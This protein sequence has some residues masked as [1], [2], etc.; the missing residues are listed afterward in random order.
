[1]DDVKATDEWQIDPRVQAQRDKIAK[2]LIEAEGDDGLGVK[3]ITKLGKDKQTPLSAAELRERD[4][5]TQADFNAK[6]NTLNTAYT[7]T[8]REHYASKTGGGGGEGERVVGLASESGGE[9]AADQDGEK[10][11]GLSSSLD[12]E[13]VEA[14]KSAQ[15]D[16]NGDKVVGLASDLFPEDRPKLPEPVFDDATF[17]DYTKQFSS[18]AIKSIGAIFQGGGELL[19]KGLNKTLDTEEFTAVNP[20]DYFSEALESSMTEGGKKALS[21][22]AFHGDVLAPE[23]WILPKSNQGKAMFVVQGFGSLATW[24]IPMGFA[25]KGTAK[26]AA[27]AGMITGGLTTGGDA[28]GDA[29]ENAEAF[30]EGKSHESLMDLVPTYK[31]AFEKY[32]DEA[33]AKQSVINNAGFLAASISGSVG[34]VEGA[35]IGKALKVM[36]FPTLPKVGAISNPIL[37]RGTAFAGGAVIEG[38]QEVLEKMG[39]NAGENIALGREATDDITRNTAGEAAGGALVGAHV[40]AAGARKDKIKEEADAYKRKKQMQDAA[41][42]LATEPTDEELDQVNDAMDSQVDAEMGRNETLSGG[43]EILNDNPTPEPQET[44]QAQVD[45]FIK[46]NKPAILLTD[47][48]AVPDNLPDDVKME[49]VEDG[50][51]IYRDDEVLKL[52]QNG[53][54][55][56]A[57]GYGIDKKPAGTNETVT[58]RDEKGTVIQDVLT[59]GSQEVLDAA[60]EVAGEDGTVEVR[61]AEE[62]I[63]ERNIAQAEEQG[64][65]DYEANQNE[66]IS[67]NTGNASLPNVS[68][69]AGQTSDNAE[70]GAT[71]VADVS[72]TADG[73]NTDIQQT[74]GIA[75]EQSNKSDQSIQQDDTE[76]DDALSKLKIGETITTGGVKYRKTEDGFVLVK[77]GEKLTLDD[78]AHDAATSERN[79]E[80]E[81]TQAQ[82]EAG[83]YKVGS[84]KVGDM[85][86]SIENPDQ[87]K[88][89]GVDRDGKAWESIMNG[90]YGYV[91][92]VVARAPDKE[93][94]DV[95]IKVGTPEDHSGDVFV[96]NQ[97]DPRTGKFDEPKV[98]IGYGSEAEARKAYE[99]NYAKGWKGLGSIAKISMENFKQRLN[100]KDGFIAP[101]VAP[102]QVDESTFKVG[103]KVKYFEGKDD[104]GELDTGTYEIKGVRDQNGE[105]VADFTN[106]KWAHLEY[107]EVVKDDG[108]TDVSD[109]AREHVTEMVKRRAAANEMGKGRLFNSILQ[110]AK[111]FMN[112]ETIRPKKLLDASLAFKGDP[113]LSKALKAL[114]DLATNKP[115]KKAE[116]EKKAPEVKAEPEKVEAKPDTTKV[117]E[118]AT[119]KA[120]IAHKRDF[121][122][123]LF[124]MAVSLEIGESQDYLAFA[125]ANSATVLEA[126]EEMRK[127]ATPEQALALDQYVK[128]GKL[129]MPAT[130]WKSAFKDAQKA[131]GVDVSQKNKLK[132][133]GIEL[134]RW[135]ELNKSK[136]KKAADWNAID[137]V[138]ARSTV[139]KPQIAE[140]A[141]ENLQP[142]LDIFR[143]TVR[144]FADYVDRVKYFN[145]YGKMSKGTVQAIKNYLNGD[146]Y[147]SKFSEDQPKSERIELIRGY[148]QE[149]LD[150]INKLNEMLNGVKTIAEVVDRVRKTAKEGVYTKLPDWIEYSESDNAYG[151][152]KFKAIEDKAPDYFKKFI[153]NYGNHYDKAEAVDKVLARLNKT[154]NDEK[155]SI[156]PDYEDWFSA[157]SYLNRIAVS[158]ADKPNLGRKLALTRPRLDKIER[159]GR[160]DY[161]KGKDVT[162]QQLKDTFGLADVIFGKYVNTVQDQKH[163]NYAF[164]ALHD[165]S[166]VLGLP[167]IAMGLGGKLHL[168]IGALGH[169]KA[170]AHYADNQPDG[171]GGTVH[172]MNFTNTRGDGTVAHEWTH[173]LDFHLKH[174][175]Q[176]GSSLLRQMRS[177]LSK[178]HTIDRAKDEAKRFILYSTY[179]PHMKNESKIN[180]AIYHLKHRGAKPEITTYKQEA[181]KLG[182]DYWGNELELL[183]RASEAYIYDQMNNAETQSDY[184]VSDWVADGKVTSKSYRGTPYPEATERKT[185]NELFKAFYSSLEADAK[186]VR[187]NKDKFNSS[188]TD[189]QIE[190]NELLEELIENMPRY[191][192]EWQ[193]EQDKARAA[194]MGESEESKAFV[195]EQARIANEAENARIEQAVEDAL[196]PNVA[197]GPLSESDLEAIF[198]EAANELTEAATEQPETVVGEPTE[199]IDT[200]T[201]ARNNTAPTSS[202]SPDTAGKI[203]AK[204]ANL[205]VKGIDE[206][207]TGLVKLFGGSDG[208]RL[209]SFPSGMDEEAYNKAK[210]HFEAALKAFIEAGKTVKDLFRFLIENFGVGIK[211]YAIRFA[212]E[213]NLS[214]QLSNDKE[215]EANESTTGEDSDNRGDATAR[216]DALQGRD[217]IEDANENSGV[218]SER[219]DGA[220]NGN[221][222]SGTQREAESSAEGTQSSTEQGAGTSDSELGDVQ[223]DRGND[224]R[225]GNYVIPVGGLTRE[226]S[227]RQSAALNLDIIELIGKLEDE[228]RQATPAEQALLSKYVGFGSAEIRNTLFNPRVFHDGKYR[229]AW[230]QSAWGAE[231]LRVEQL[232]TPEQLKSVLRSTQYAHY[233]P[234]SMTRSIWAGL[235]R[236]GYSGGKVFEAG[237]GVGNFFGTMPEGMAKASNYTGVEYDQLTASIAKQLYPNENV[238]Q[239]D[240]TETKLPDN[241]FD[242][243]IGNPPFSQTRITNDP[244]YRKKSFVMHDYFI[245]KSLDKVREG[246]LAVF[247]TSKGTMDALNDRARKDISSQ[248]DLIGAIRMPQTAFKENA[249]TETITDVI[250]LRKR[251]KSEEAGGENWTGH[252]ELKLHDSNGNQ[253]KMLVNEYFVKHPEMVL[254]NHAV[255]WGQRGHEYTVTPFEDQTIE[256]GFAKAVENLPENVYST[257]KASKDTAIKAV[258]ERDLN[259]LNKK[260]GGM[261]VDDKGK[262]MVVDSG[263]GVAASSIFNLNSNTE[264]WLKDYVKVRDAVKQS[265]YDQW[266]DAN[267]EASLKAL[268]KVYD[269]FVKKH[270]S[271]KAFTSSFRNETDD[272]GVVTKMERRRFKNWSTINKDV[273]GAFV[274]ALED[275]DDTGNI[276]KAA[277]LTKRTAKKPV[278]VKIETIHDALAVSLD[279]VGNLD[280]DIIAE[281]MSLTK[282]QVISELGDMIYE[283][284]SDNE[285]QMHDEYLSGKVIDKLEEAE[286]AAKI[287]HRFERNVKALLKVQPRPIPSS[288]ITVNLGVNWIKPDVIEA[289]AEEVLEEGVSVKYGIA[290]GTW[291]ADG[292]GSRGYQR[293]STTSWGTSD[294]SAAEILTAVLNGK[295]LEI[296]RTDQETKKT[297]TDAVATA[298]VNDIANKMRDSF[299]TWVWIDS[300]RAAALT[301]TYN[302]EFNNVVG[303]TFDGSHMS[304]AGMTTTIDLHPHQKR[305]IWRVVQTGSTYLDHAVGAGKTYEM[306]ASGMEQRRLGLIRRPMYVVP[307]HMLEQFATE[308]IDLYPTANIMVA[309]KEN[310]HADTR[311]RFLAQASMNDPDAI[312]ITHSAF[313]LLGLSAENAN[314]IIEEQ[315]DEL[316]M[317]LDEVEADGERVSI[318]KIQQ[319]IESLEKKLKTKG[320]TDAKDDAITFEDMGVDMLYVDEAHEFRK[321]DFA[322]NKTKVKGIDPNGSAKAMDLYTK[323]RYLQSLN[324]TRSHVFASGTPVTNTMGELYTIMKFFARDE[325]EQ[326]GLMHFDS[327]AAMF[328]DVVADYEPNA[329]G[330]YELVERFAKFQNVPELMKRIRTF[331]DVLTSNDLG[332]L[333]TRPTIKGGSRTIVITPMPQALREY[334]DNVL[335]PRIAKSKAWKP[336]KSEPNN[337]DPIIAIIGDARLA[338]ID[339]R[340]VNPE[341]E[342]DPDSKLN[343]MID[344]IIETFNRSKNTVYHDAWTKIA[345]KIKG[346]TQIVFANVGFGDQVAKNRGFSAKDW[347]NKRLKDAGMKQSEIAWMGEYN[348]SLKKEAMFMQMRSGEKKILFGSPKNMG[349]GVNVQS[350]LFALHYLDA[351]WY[352]SDLEQ[353]EGRIYRQKNKNPEIELNAYATKGSYDS[354]MWQTVARKGRFIE[355]AFNGDDSVRT[356]E[357]VSESSNYQMAAALASG[358]DRVVKLAGLESAIGKLERLKS[359][360]SRTQNELRTKMVANGATIRSLTERI[361]DSK[362][363]VKKTNDEYLGSSTKIK[364]GKKE[365]VVAKE[366]GE[367]IIELYQKLAKT[368]TK[369]ADTAEI[370]V[371]AGK[372]SLTREV[373]SSLGTTEPTLTINVTDK[374]KFVID[375]GS[376]EGKDPSGLVSRILNQINRV[377]T[378]LQEQEM[379]LEGAEREKKNIESKLGAPY[380]N[381]QELNEKIAEAAQ[382]KEELASTGDKAEIVEA[383]SEAATDENVEYWS[384]AIWEN[385][386]ESIVKATRVD[387]KRLVEADARYKDIVLFKHYSPQSDD[388]SVTEQT[389]GRRITHDSFDK[390]EAQAIDAL[391]THG[392]D[393]FKSLVDKSATVS[394]VPKRWTEDDTAFLTENGTIQSKGLPLAEVEKLAAQVAKGWKRAPEI[395]VIENL[396][397]PRVNQSVRDK[398][399]K[400]EANG[401]KKIDLP[402]A[403]ISSGKVY[404]VRSK[405]NNIRQVA[406]AVHHEIFGHYGLRNNFGTALNNILD[407]IYIGR[408]DEVKA[409]AKAYG[410]DLNIPAERRL[411]AEEV[412][413]EMAQKNPQLGLVQRAI[414]AIRTWLR[415]TFDYYKD[416]EITDAEIINSILIPARDFVKNSARSGDGNLLG[417]K[418]L[419]PVYSTGNNVAFNKESDETLFNLPKGIEFKRIPVNTSAMPRGAVEAFIDG[420]KVGS[421][422]LYVR[423]DKFEV[424]TIDV[425]KEYRRQGIASELI[426]EAQRYV[427]VDKLFTTLQTPEGKKL[428]STMN[429]SPKGDIPNLLDQTKTASFKK[430]FGDSKVVD[431]NGNPKVMYHGTFSNPQIFEEGVSEFGNVAGFF[432]PSPYFA[433]DY[434]VKYWEAKDAIDVNEKS[435]E[436]VSIQKVYIKAE[437]PFDYNNKAHVKQLY[438]KIKDIESDEEISIDSLSTGDYR[439]YESSREI[440]DEI[441]NLGFDSVWVKESGVKNITVFN[442]NQIKS[443]IGNNGNFDANNDDIAFS[444]ANSQQSWEDLQPNSLSKTLI[445]ALQDKNVD[446]KEV[447]KNIKKSVG[448]IADKVNAYLQEELYHGRTAKRTKDFIKTELEPLIDSMRLRGVEM[449]DFEEYLWARHA[450]ERNI[451]IAKINPEMP[452]GGSGMMTADAIGYLKRL[453]PSQ[454]R[455]FEA[456]AKRID[457]ISKKS[458]Q[459]LV[460]YGI[461][462]KSTIAAWEGAY[463]HYVPLM[464]EDMDHGFGNG[465]G[466]GF[467]VKGNA[468]KRATGSKRAVVDIIANLAQ[469]RE[470]N[471]IRGEKNRVSTALIG[472]AKA[473]PNPKFW[474]TEKPPTITTVSKPSS[475][476][477]VLY[478][479]SRVRSFTTENAAKDYIAYEGKNG[480]TIDEIKIPARVVTTIDP[481]YKNRNEVIVARIPDENGKIKEMSVIFNEHDKRAMRM[482]ASLKNLDQDQ[483]KEVL[484]ASAS[485][486]RYFASINT[487][488]NPI[489][490]LINITR[491]V[492]GSILNLSSTPLK[493]KQ[494]EVLK[495]TGS[496]LLGIYRDLRKVRK[497]GKGVDSK[498][499]KLFEE[500]Q[501]EGGQTGYRDMFRNAEARGNAIKKT[502]DPTW[503]QNTKVGKAVTLNGLIAKPEQ[504]LLEKGQA[505]IFDFLSDY[506][507]ALENAVRLSTYKVAKDNGQTNQQAASLAKNISVNFN[508]KGEM[509]REVGSLYAF[510]NASVQG[511]ARIM[512][513]MVKSEDGKISFTKAGAKIFYGG[514]LLGAIQAVMLA[515]FGY[516]EDEPPKF[517]RDRSLII[518]LD[519][520]GADKKYITIPMPLGF[521]AIPSTGRILTEWMLSGFDD[522]NERFMGFMDMLLDVTNPIGNAGMSMQT[523]T[524]TALDPIAALTENKDWTGKP[525]A[526]EDFNSLNPTAGHTRGRDT[527]SMLGNGISH[528]INWMTGGNE[529]KAGVISPTPDH[530]DYLIGQLAGGVGREAMKIQQAITAVKTG[531]E[532]PPYKRPVIGRFYGEA[533]SKS[534][535]GGKFYK[536]IIRLNKLE[537]ELKGRREAKDDV[538]GFRKDNPEVALISYANAAQSSISRLRKQKRRLIENNASKDRIEAVNELI[539][540]KMRR[541]NEKVYSEAN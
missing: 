126:I 345:E 260:E 48:E 405:V 169:G 453:T 221:D 58:A 156:L 84:V 229:P 121:D 235:E 364:V 342:S 263:S 90:H 423:G 105:K 373:V 349:T 308:F 176:Q 64:I 96:I 30:F 471:L 468:S 512:E 450:E 46:G 374:V 346:S 154:L 243:T 320:E 368:H 159:K 205:G 162:P 390:V 145:T 474:R 265:R 255:R 13:W 429:A 113:A 490:G 413:A 300:N 11:V 358:D 219:N 448:G 536:N 529:Y 417:I 387:T 51:L 170:A 137:K 8:D 259:P 227:W 379:A 148:A 23:T 130:F 482:S 198:D 140:G 217:P 236:L 525:I 16:E 507:D 477:D 238:I 99:S 86:V 326:T 391:I 503:W 528:A 117:D 47:G 465:T 253:V 294:R 372:Y 449:A 1:M 315:L 56:E 275:V 357:D 54:I 432:T 393:K 291:K 396:D 146:S 410:L 257:A 208:G 452:D 443:A 282:D 333:V 312:I 72:D 89:K 415:K 174:Y 386:K 488:Y 455:N 367:A 322:T 132:N 270:G 195:A 303:R 537:T 399:V 289:F 269:G 66:T 68:R 487:Q 472:L 347:V 114:Y 344:G 32:G 266:N 168:A 151:K 87:S 17:A 411:A 355:Q 513:T 338:N 85:V 348:T 500:F 340:F 77:D 138:T 431:E 497:S 516:D 408:R 369:P 279:K 212:K 419:K 111:D 228:K 484:S 438:N 177:L 190:Y 131:A 63:E 302:R 189:P 179:Y 216:P 94:V 330:R 93:H 489:F 33:R 461:E 166:D 191:A 459:V 70:T 258:A 377:S 21:E 416:S 97:N 53:Q 36:K 34:A 183:A 161:R 187:V 480:F 496:A 382:L 350:R 444:L 104:Y 436:A 102:R 224:G 252:E 65:A 531:E 424:A 171:K 261:Y 401:A 296:K 483:M 430:W 421:V 107:L 539:T 101:V 518:P 316:R 318:K 75:D 233:T 383:A 321:L 299:K 5:P 153:D 388:W 511:T 79:D 143:G 149:Y 290:T 135:W 35:Y 433:E 127:D 4:I 144:T 230:V 414:A 231:A 211:P 25:A 406:E 173:A 460:D 403:F 147:L 402:V 29:R 92:G 301:A 202:E 237:M 196:N 341:S 108:K 239:G 366:S 136:A 242:L 540:N 501:N 394:H 57:L 244:K 522:T 283:S 10:V 204:A 167:K 535:E 481:S 37:R 418:G 295:S 304:L 534:S 213:N 332:T 285:W 22:S 81:P 40:S 3:N 353:P 498:W 335:M 18:S 181:D 163:L 381:E 164:D 502:L 517:V 27:T 328:G 288:G 175:D 9:V 103:E 274:W 356:L 337:P 280:L 519:I 272:D 434:V 119:K 446:L 277:P 55:G 533:K 118:E 157:S 407:Q 158:K 50:L 343:K 100:M 20:L 26:L 371:I 112:G 404:I 6:D 352:P 52:A 331:M 523:V 327:W 43:G 479:G 286:A 106:G 150:E 370:A 492:Q 12:D 254:G 123:N 464:R 67:D 541:F 241:F 395:I 506:N 336:S 2:E 457:A 223:A 427:G 91:K 62:A 505:Y 426:R 249:G 251:G 268:N 339:M 284:P 376:L 354:S 508:R 199:K 306:I 454:L 184:L 185:F 378:K 380:E 234:E 60:A 458:R 133:T 466:Q 389:T 165:L 39:G 287:D 7:G 456:L 334:M 59:D 210:P 129:V 409:K 324:P 15:A 220:D 128:D 447:T 264:A 509:G 115:A 526:L 247:V 442:S 473:N 325:L 192:Q 124:N 292:R 493:G 397:D 521:N 125:K 469:Q 420:K 298:A 262:L 134:R 110:T 45:S 200:P 524:P 197:D 31:I 186:G 74:D 178:T 309:E 250:I 437:N 467:S 428:F 207:L 14:P 44:L 527:S 515:L 365:S 172:V 276:T 362:E 19:A 441:K 485:V 499:A 310:F 384:H 245:V 98:Y 273:E 476:F 240:F 222:G 215:G 530:I 510:F 248:A 307:N 193:A 141:D 491:D 88:R 82:K 69:N 203:A 42:K 462:S 61:T 225:S 73:G 76:S 451:Q 188:F 323:V 218:E 375:T 271:I 439:V 28:A 152:H 78:K 392:Y 359:A 278:E 478:H 311:R 182:K 504:W 38:G 297:Y 385:D 116:P 293:N 180:Q 412:L 363:A 281:T 122:R 226:G 538:A 520:L 139:F 351:P 514:L 313:G 142:Y 435:G 445:Y 256:D 319:Q 232:M 206:A 246:G 422:S 305:A 155:F 361:A 83:N 329:A 475:T 486:T 41:H 317:V 440:F 267:W 398:L 209:N 160:K 71:V 49:I 463:K 80:L 194:R 470:K 532:L 24:I 120:V 360:H 314:K 495:H 400:M 494:A 425:V 95:N 109:Q 201:R 214:S